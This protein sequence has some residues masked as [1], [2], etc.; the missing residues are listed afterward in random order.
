MIRE[1]LRDSLQ[2]HYNH[3]DMFDDRSSA[4]YKALLWIVRDDVLQISP[5]DPSRLLQ[6]FIL[7]CLYYSTK[8]DISWKNKYNFLT[9][10]HECSWNKKN[11]SHALVDYENRGIWCKGYTENITHIWLGKYQKIYIQL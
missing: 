6:R 9:S 3:V 7:A 1:I 8:G 10:T 11:A 4:E 5:N 2:D